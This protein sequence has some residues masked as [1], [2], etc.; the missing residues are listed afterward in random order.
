MMGTRLKNWSAVGMN[1]PAIM[2]WHD[3][4]IGHSKL[5]TVVSALPRFMSMRVDRIGMLNAA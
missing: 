2:I 1:S 3:T 4:G 5:K